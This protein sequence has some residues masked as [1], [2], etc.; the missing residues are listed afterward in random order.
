MFNFGTPYCIQVSSPD[1]CSRLR[2]DCFK[3]KEVEALCTL[4]VNSY[5][6]RLSGLAKLPLLMKVQSIT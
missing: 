3:A 6:D 4:V 1:L 5:T 2:N